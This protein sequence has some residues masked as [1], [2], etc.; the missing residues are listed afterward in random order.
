MSAGRRARFARG[1]MA[2]GPR[3][4]C[5]RMWTGPLGAGLRITAT[6]DDGVRATS[7]CPACTSSSAGSLGGAVGVPVV[8]G[9]HTRNAESIGA[10]IA[11][12]TELARTGKLSPAQLT[13]GASFT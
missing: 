3:P 1:A 8:R 10:E 4:C 2:V 6:V 9:A 5:A 12:L 7:G 13:G 11:R